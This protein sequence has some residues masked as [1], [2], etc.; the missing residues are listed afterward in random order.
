MR[1][2]RMMSKSFRNF[3]PA[4]K[5]NLPHPWERDSNVTACCTIGP[6]TFFMR[7]IFDEESI[8]DDLLFRKNGSGVFSEAVATALISPIS[9][10]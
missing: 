9:F 8:G 4:S 1:R 2:E 5:T 6:A 3:S 7:V 10:L